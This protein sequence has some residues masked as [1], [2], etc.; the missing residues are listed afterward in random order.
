MKKTMG[1][2]AVSFAVVLGGVG[3]HYLRLSPATAQDA[4]ACTTLFD[5]A[6]KAMQ[7]SFEAKQAFRISAPTGA[8]VA[9]DL[10]TCPQGWEP[11]QKLAGRVVIG[12]GLEPGSSLSPRKY[13]DSGGEEMHKLS[14]AELPSHNHANGQFKYM[15]TSNGSW[16]IAASGQDDSSGEPNLAHMGEIQPLGGDQPHNNMQPYYT[17][18]FCRRT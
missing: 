15:L 2:A 1:I 6:Q 9:F 16:T 7:A 13:Q 4:A 8:V 10:P 17:L 5:C 14:V 3:E 18:T 11:F 12:A